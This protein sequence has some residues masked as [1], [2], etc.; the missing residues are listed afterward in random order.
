MSSQ[1]NCDPLKMT[2][3]DIIRA[4][5]QRHT[6]K[7]LARAMSAPIDTARTWLYRSLSP[8]RRRELALALIAEY[9]RQDREERPV[10]RAQLLAMVGDDVSDKMDGPRSFGGDRAGDETG[11]LAASTEARSPARRVG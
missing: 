9:D 11:E 4:V 8:V 5:Y 2:D 3:A 7:R 1:H 6:M 10:V